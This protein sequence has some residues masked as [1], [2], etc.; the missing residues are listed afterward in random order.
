MGELFRRGGLAPELEGGDEPVAG[1]ELFDL[2]AP[3]ISAKR[4]DRGGCRSGRQQAGL[5]QLTVNAKWVELIGQQTCKSF[6]RLG[7]SRH[8]ARGR[9]DWATISLMSLEEMYESFLIVPPSFLN[10]DLLLLLSFPFSRH[11]S[12]LFLSVSSPH[13]TCLQL[14]SLSSYLRVYQ[15]D[16]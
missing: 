3:D 12:S 4:S 8:G 5:E 15:R 6:P 13:N 16:L 2:A 10:P 11:H 9:V 14:L 1:A 7:W